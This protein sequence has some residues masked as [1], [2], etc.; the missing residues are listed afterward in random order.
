MSSFELN[1][2][3]AAVLVAG[4][5]LMVA[6]FLSQ[7]LVKP[8]QLEKNVLV[9]EGVDQPVAATASAEPAAAAIEPVSA[10]LAAADVKAGEAVAK[11]CAACH[12]FDK[13]GANRVGPNLW[14]I[15]GN[16]H[17]HADGFA[18]SDAIKGMK[19]K[20]WS[21]EELNHFIA[22]PKAYAPGTKMAFAGIRK[23]E[24]RAQ[25]IAYLRSL[26]DTPVPLP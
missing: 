12:T 5:V 17:A 14:G 16:H 18:Y 9:V 1:K 8:H 24:E 23:T 25:L 22:N 20:P 4:I 26:A 6:G 13:G 7:G 15:V 11:R 21:Y 10:L 3:A 2:I 19:D